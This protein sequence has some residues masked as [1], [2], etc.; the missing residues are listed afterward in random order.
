[1][2]KLG[3]TIWSLRARLAGAFAGRKAIVEKVTEEQTVMVRRSGKN[4]VIDGEPT[5][6]RVIENVDMQ[7]FRTGKPIIVDDI[8]RQRRT[9]R[10]IVFADGE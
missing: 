10:T 9:E 8:R 7:V 6:G 5:L 1:M 4:I 3:D 2:E